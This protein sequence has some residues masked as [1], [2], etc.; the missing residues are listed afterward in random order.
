MSVVEECFR[1]VCRFATIARY[2]YMYELEMACEGDVRA[3]AASK[4]RPSFRSLLA[5][6][7][8]VNTLHFTPRPRVQ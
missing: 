1:G 4:A 3:R 8:V 5:V 2:I 6:K 7:A